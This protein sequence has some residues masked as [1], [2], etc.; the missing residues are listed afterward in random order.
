[1]CD[2]ECLV[3]MYEY[4]VQSCANRA[5]ACELQRESF[6]QDVYLLA[7]SSRV[8]HKGISDI[9]N[10]HGT[11][12][13]LYT[14]PL[15]LNLHVSDN[16]HPAL[17]KRPSPPAPLAPRSGLPADRPVLEMKT[18]KA[19]SPRRRGSPLGREAGGGGWDSGNGIFK[20]C[21]G[22][23]DKRRGW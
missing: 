4:K 17:C 22:T 5:C 21:R 10:D 15:P 23:G 3:G 20:M 2:A 14:A 1:M 8:H 12:Y 7:W 13:P 11:L 19:R 9:K 6:G 16:S 18:E